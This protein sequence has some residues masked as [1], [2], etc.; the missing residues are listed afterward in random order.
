MSQIDMNEFKK[1]AVLMG[2][3]SPERAVSLKSGDAAYRAL[4]EQGIHCEAIDPRDYPIVRLAEDGF[5]HAFIALHGSGG[6]DGI[7]QAVL[8]NIGVP[9]TGSRVLGSA[10]AMDKYR[11]KNLWN[12]L[13][14]PTPECEAVTRLTDLEAFKK[15]LTLP[16]MVK[17]SIEGSSIGMTK[18]TE[19][20]AL[21]QAV[22]CAFDFSDVVLIE[23]WIDGPEYTVAILDGVVLPSIRIEVAEDFY[24]YS[25]KYEANTTRYFCPSGL[26]A[27]EESAL[28][29]LSL[30]A[31]SALG[32]SGW[33]RVD[34]M[35]DKKGA[36]Y[37]LEANTVPGLTDHSLVPM[38]AEQANIAFGA[39]MLKIL[40]TARL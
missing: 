38:A 35:R 5:S 19:V 20:T 11:T 4:K 23:R 12:G 32:C 2:G 17:P 21:E 16:C 6:E 13:A 39:L 18:V 8:E 30:K 34:V 36:F 15:T 14:I 26:T 27:E 7:T 1:V 24:D 9:Y 40:A 29:A 33:G 37:C 28:Q 10:L 3:N 31:F 25:A 22:E